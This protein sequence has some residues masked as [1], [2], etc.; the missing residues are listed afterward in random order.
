[1]NVAHLTGIVRMRWQLMR[2]RLSKSGTANAVISMILLV[3]AAIASLSSF[4]FAVVAGGFL[5]SR[6]QPQYMI[7]VWDALA[8]AFL[9]GWAI[10]I[11]VEL[12]QAETMSLKN[13]LHLPISLANAFVLNYASSFASLTVLLFLPAMIGVCVASVMQYGIASLWSFAL[14][15]S[16]LLM[17][18]AVTHLVRGWLARL[19]ENKRTRGTVIV[20]TTISFVVLA[21]LPQF[22]TSGGLGIATAARPAQEMRQAFQKDK[23][24]FLEQL[25]A[26]E[27]SQEEYDQFLVDRTEKFD[28]D[29][30]ARRDAEAARLHEI[31]K[32]TNAYL[33]IGWLP[34]GATAAATGG[35]PLK[36]FLCVLGMSTIGL[37]ALAFS[38]RSTIRAYT[39][40]HTKAPKTGTR[41]SAP[42][43]STSSIL[44]NSIPLLTNQQSTIAL[45]TFRSTL[46]APEG[47]MAL[48]TPLI[49]VCVF[50]SMILSGAMDKMPDQ[51]RPFVGLSAIGMSL[52]GVIQMLVNMF[53]LDRQGFRAWVLMPVS[54]RDI[55]LGKNLG[56]LPIMFALTAS[57]V[58]FASIATGNRVTHT[59]ATLM[60]IPIA[61]LI[62]YVITNYTSIAAPIGMAAGT[63]KPA[64][65]K[66][67]V[68]VVQFIA[69]LLTP[70]AIMPAA[71]ALGVDVLLA[72]FAG[73]RGV[74]VYLLLTAIELPVAWLFY[75]YMLNLQGDYLQDREQHILEVISKVAD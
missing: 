12:Q 73:L 9:F 29:N 4:V 35:G 36:P 32:T 62:C 42:E 68:A 46:R 40:E 6:M 75:S 22:L 15:A 59:L 38:Y 53:G 25:E 74:P 8:G 33:P 57:L 26:N 65:L 56:L 71:F 45:T 48:L 34:Y 13:L 63:M 20:V 37:V 60:Q 67:S 31:A 69:V 23:E 7:Y 49:F 24:K 5:L 30:K 19:M 47:K 50:G 10:A 2:N 1:M 66:F 28:A 39:G 58:L 41:K 16:F 17:V 55:L 61:F 21:Q 51:L 70:L 3:I 43:G 18:T 52:L 27:I 11:M 64:N 14:L 44:E 72:E 54:R